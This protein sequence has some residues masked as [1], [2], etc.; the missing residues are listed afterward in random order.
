MSEEV[1]I[2]ALVAFQDIRASP[3][4][5]NKQKALFLCCCK[6]C[7]RTEVQVRRL[8]VT[9]S[10]CLRRIV[11]MKLTDSHRLETKPEQCGMSPWE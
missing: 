4:H 10:I 7:T 2:S 3:K 8:E 1:D 11:S 9:H 5:S 6:T